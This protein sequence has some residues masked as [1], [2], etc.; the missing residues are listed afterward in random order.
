M[1]AELRAEPMEAMKAI[2]WA[3]T[4]QRLANDAAQSAYRV[5]WWIRFHTFLWFILPLI[6]KVVVLAVS[7]SIIGLRYI[8]T[9][10]YRHSSNIHDDLFVVVVMLSWLMPTI[11]IFFTFLKQV[12]REKTKFRRQIRSMYF[13]PIKDLEI[14]EPIPSIVQRLV[15]LMGIETCVRFWKNSRSTACLPSLIMERGVGNLVLPIGFILLSEK[16]PRVAAAILAHELAHIKQKDT[17]LWHTAHIYS[18]NLSAS[19]RKVAKIVVLWQ[20]TIGL[21]VLFLTS[22][23]IARGI[24]YCAELII[25]ICFL[26]AGI[27]HVDKISNEVRDH[28]RHSENGADRYACYYI[29]GQALTE[30]L[31]CYS[32][33]ANEA[34]DECFHL[35]KNARL[36]R[37]KELGI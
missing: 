15:K 13:L 23:T 19:L 31:H 18:R 21:I 29:G 37:I 20:L 33:D 3:D 11:W 32:L 27:F 9:A 6:V 8:N 26:F 22:P 1:D 14:I 12:M 10:G 28:L 17:I 7:F 5:T 2:L 4:T 24:A 34:V 25:E 36:Q 35:P 30:A 16:S